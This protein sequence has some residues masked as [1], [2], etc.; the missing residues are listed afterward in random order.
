MDDTT[1]DV[2][3]E[4]HDGTVHDTMF[5]VNDG[6]PDPAPGCVSDTVRVTCGLPDVVTN[7]TIAPRD[8]DVVFA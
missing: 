7:V 3:V 2:D 4:Y 6:P 8:A 1:T 5:T